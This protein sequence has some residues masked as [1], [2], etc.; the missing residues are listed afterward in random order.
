MK[1]ISFSLLVVI[2][3]SV[4]FASCEKKIEKSKGVQPVME[5]FICG[6]GE[7]KSTM[8]SVCIDSIPDCVMTQYFYLTADRKKYPIYQS[9]TGKCFIVRTSSKTG[10][11]YRQYLPEVDKQLNRK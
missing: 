2:I 7:I 3:C 5:R 6:G 1:K 8:D 11:R 10:E 9:K 4:C